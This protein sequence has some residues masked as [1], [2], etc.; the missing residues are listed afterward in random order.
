LKESFDLDESNT[1]F[2]LMKLVSNI[3]SQP[4]DDNEIVFDERMDF[5]E[6]GEERKE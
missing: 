4:G 6:G 2:S 3:D 5:G 1:N